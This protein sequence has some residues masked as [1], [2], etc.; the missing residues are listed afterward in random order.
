MV[1]NIAAPTVKTMSSCRATSFYLAPGVMRYFRDS[2]LMAVSP[3]GTWIRIEHRNGVA[4]LQK[5]QP[6]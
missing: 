3:D 2:N 4:R 6:E 1:L 5:E